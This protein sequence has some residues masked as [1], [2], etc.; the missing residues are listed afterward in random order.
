MS[1]VDSCWPPSGSRHACSSSGASGPRERVEERVG[2]A[3]GHCPER[4]LP[5][6][7]SF[8][9]KGT[10]A[11]DTPSGTS[12]GC[13]GLPCVSI[14]VSGLETVSCLE[15][16][17]PSFQKVRPSTPRSSPDPS[18]IPSFQ[19]VRPSALRSSPVPSPVHSDLGPMLRTFQEEE[20]V[21]CRPWSHSMEA[22]PRAFEG[23]LGTLSREC[24]GTHL[25]T[26]RP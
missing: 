13:F 21:P 16:A 8:R 11:L 24:R 20:D 2:T 7:T 6:R 3:R 23:V 1:L 10:S 26:R 22:V 5:R 19:K 14:L 12:S 4:G 25:P 17:V 9:D 15:I 18:P